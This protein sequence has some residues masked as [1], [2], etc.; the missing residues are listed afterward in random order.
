MR[1]LALFLG[2]ILSCTAAVAA[3]ADI[4]SN[5][6]VVNRPV[7]VILV[8]M[9][10]QRRQV[11]LTSGD[12]E[13]PVGVWVAIESHVGAT[14]NIVSDAKTSVDEKIAVKSEDDARILR[15]Q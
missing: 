8:N 5:V 14:L 9:S 2:S 6:S 13:L 4:P 7:R 10:G 1:T 12:V 3:H 11:R 15:V